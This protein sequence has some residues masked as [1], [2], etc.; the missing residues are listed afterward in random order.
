[1]AKF[2][3]ISF[4]IH[5]NWMADANQRLEFLA[6]QAASAK[7]SIALVS[8]EMPLRANLSVLDNI[9]LIPQ[10]RANLTYDKAADLAWDLLAAAGYQD[11]FAKR[12]PDLSHAERFVAKLLRAAIGAPP[13]ILIDRPAML[14]P[15]THYPPFLRALLK[16]L[17]NYLNDCRIIDYQWNKPLYDVEFAQAELIQPH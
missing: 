13:I 2:W 8:P 9:A 6:A 3:Q 1:M 14:L 7:E 4:Q 12:D 16:N 15:D 17:V 11:S 10:Y 5:M